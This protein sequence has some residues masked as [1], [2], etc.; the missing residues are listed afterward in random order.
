MEIEL[1]ELLDAKKVKTIILTGIAGIG[2]TW[3][4]RRITNIARKKNIVD[5]ALWISA[6]GSYD[7]TLL[8]DCITDKYF[9]LSTDGESTDDKANESKNEEER[10]K[11]QEEERKKLQDRTRNEVK[12]L[13]KLLLVVDDDGYGKSG[14]S[15]E[16]VQKVLELLKKMLK[17]DTL[18]YKVLIIRRNEVVETSQRMASSNITE[19]VATSEETVKVTMQPLKR[20]ETLSLLKERAGTEAFQ[21]VKNLAEDIVEKTEGIPAAILLMA[22]A[23][24]YF[25]PKEAGAELLKRFLKEVK[26]KHL[27]ECG[28]ELQPKEL[29]S[30]KVL[31]DCCW[32]GSHF[33]RD[34]GR[35]HHMELIAYW[36]LEGY[37]GD[38]DSVE[39]AYEKGHQVLMELLDCQILKKVEGDYVVIMEGAKERLDKIV[40]QNE[41]LS[42][43]DCY[44]HGFCGTASLGLANVLGEEKG[45]DLRKRYKFSFSL[46]DDNG[47]SRKFVSSSFR[48]LQV[49]HLIASFNPTVET[50]S[51]STDIDSPV[52]QKFEFFNKNQT[53]GKKSLDPYVLVF[54]GCHF[55]EMVELNSNF[56]NLTVLEIS[57]PSPLKSI[58]ENFFWHTPKLQSL[59]LSAHQID[60]LPT[61]LFELDDLRWLILRNCSNLE[62]LSSIKKCKKLMVLDLSGAK[63]LNRI[64]DKTFAQNSCL[65]M[66]NFS[67]TKIKRF[68][69]VNNLPK[70]T[71]LLL[72]GCTE[73]VRLPFT[74]GIKTLEVL[75]LSGSSKVEEL[76]DQKLEGLS[77]L[78]IF[79]LSGTA[80]ANLPSNLGNSCH[81]SL[82][83]CA[84]LE[85]LAF[86]ETLEHLKVLDVSKALFTTLPSLAKLSNLRRLSLLNCPNLLE[87]PDSSSL[88]K[89]EELN[90]WGCSAL[91]KLQ[92]TSFEKLSWLQRLDLS[93]TMI[94]SL[95]SLSCLTNLHH[96]SLKRCTE[97]KELPELGSLSKLQELNLCGIKN[98]GN[99]VK[100]VDFFKDM[101]Q[102]QILDLSETEL[103]SI[104]SLSNLTKLCQ[105]Y[106]RGLPSLKE[107]QGLEALTGLEVLDLS[108]TSVDPLPYLTKFTKLRHVLFQDVETANQPEDCDTK[109]E[110]TNQCSW[111]V[112]C[113]PSGADGIDYNLP[114][115]ISGSRFLEPSRL[116]RFPLS[117]HPIN[118]QDRNGTDVLPF[119]DIYRRSKMFQTGPEDVLCVPESVF[120]IDN[121]SEKW[122]SFLG[123]SNL[124]KLEGCWIERCSKM[125]SILR[126][127]EAEEM[128]KLESLKL[129]W[130]SNCVNL[131]HIYHGNRQSGTFQN[132]KHLYIDCCPQLSFVFSSSQQ[133]INVKVLHIKFCDKLKTLFEPDSTELLLPE[134]MELYL[135]E[136]PELEKIGCQLPPKFELKKSECPKLE[137][138]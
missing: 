83:D 56:E 30:N 129:L 47:S 4:A 18:Q 67:E 108:G 19:V 78:E 10:K 137:K 36:I 118:E 20:D 99:I 59:N 93:E 6:G 114:L 98:L 44:R 105:L 80:V 109:K 133:P 38:V 89:L 41:I 58:P 97:V 64:E 63:S 55:L 53:D 104:P 136:L 117:I 88:E 73:L 32:P 135:W 45:N 96:L 132:L 2:K 57:G 71:H 113:F 74:N 116:K 24:S 119:M 51:L 125:K 9:P 128:A 35:S 28:Y 79:D 122:F 1:L 69:I 76:K 107:V 14:T 124:K 39:K 86:I 90:L 85:N 33:Y 77:A 7:E 11:L 52:F 43:D 72:R 37:L 12:I 66:L 46:I 92:G 5:D 112:S 65:Q 17:H 50:L 91:K 26:I 106:L 25:S 131:N 84:K 75:D 61:S 62:K 16:D 82:K 81:L 23:V 70:L 101:S 130:V 42:L 138:V 27:L 60:S 102:L 29:Q 13:M 134:L 54:R 103:N 31:I 115:T 22:K 40:M 111:A 48:S 120:L 34:C 95:P 121:G 127:E 126:D 94:E 123:A 8:W 21:R 3:A 68:P 100:G 110:E 49:H 87:L 15:T